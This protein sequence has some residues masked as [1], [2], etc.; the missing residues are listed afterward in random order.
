MK[1]HELFRRLLQHSNAK[2]L[3]ARMNLSTSMLYKWAEPSADGGSGV[4]NPLDRV[5]QLM[6]CADGRGI[7]Q[8]VCEQVAG[9]YVQNPDIA[10]RKGSRSVIVATNKIV[11]EFA[12]MLSLIAAAA[13]DNSIT[14]Q[15]AADIR[16]R[17]E[18]LKSATEEYVN[19][20]EQGNFKEIRE[21]AR[22]AHKATGTTRSSPH[23]FPS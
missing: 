23:S 19:C 20:C 21:R 4:L 7:A 18:C 8:W 5:A 9:F 12:D 16:A 13:L 17:W 15:E 6:Q 11:Q 14:E 1:S 3:A 2:E 22:R 10:G